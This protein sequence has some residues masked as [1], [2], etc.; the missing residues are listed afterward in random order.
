MAHDVLKKANRAQTWTLRK[1]L[2]TETDL[3]TTSD[4][5]HDKTCKPEP[6]K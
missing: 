5:V 6:F 4:Y 3:E 2:E 1:G